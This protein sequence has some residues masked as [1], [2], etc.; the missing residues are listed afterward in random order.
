[1]CTGRLLPPGPFY[2]L[3]IIAYPLDLS[4]QTLN[5]TIMANSKFQ[6]TQYDASHFVESVGAIAINI[7]DWIIGGLLTISNALT[8]QTQPGASIYIPAKTA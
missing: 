2:S 3:L 5:H 4:Q 1:M 8:G 6:T 7:Y